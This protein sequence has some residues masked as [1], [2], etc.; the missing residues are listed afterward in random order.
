MGLKVKKGA[1]ALGIKIRRKKQADKMLACRHELKYRITESQAAA[2]KKYLQPYLPVD[3]YSQKYKDGQYPISS[4]YFDSDRLTLCHE[5]LTGKKNRFKLRLRAY[6]D[7]IETPRF[8]EI[9][10][11]MNNVIIKS[12]A[13]ISEEAVAPILAGRD[14]TLGLSG[15]DRKAV[16]QFQLYSKALAARPMVLVRYLREAY[17]DST[18]NRVRITFD[19]QIYCKSANEPKVVLNGPGWQK[20]PIDF[21]VLEIKFTSRYPAWLSEMIKAINLPLSAMSKYASSVKQT[22]LLGYCAP[23]TTIKKQIW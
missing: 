12:R 21:V 16:H 10:R 2:V 14:Y 23:E 22:C 17:E 11:R 18:D 1:T 19:R 4:L 15:N 7:D 8:L 5:T 6:S 9:K 3:R 20:M 13:R